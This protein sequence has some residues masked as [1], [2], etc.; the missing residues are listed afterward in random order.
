VLANRH[1]VCVECGAEIV[2]V[3]GQPGQLPKRCD[4]CWIANKQRHAEEARLR[5]MADPERAERYRERGRNKVAQWRANHPE[6][7]RASDRATQARRWQDPETRLRMK[8]LRAERKYGLGQGGYQMFLDRQGHACA[9]C[10]APFNAEYRLA[11]DHDHRC[12]DSKTSC[13][14]CVR[15]LLCTNC[16]RALAAFLDDPARMRAAADYVERFSPT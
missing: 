14:K 8:H 2:R 16:N 4:P 15:G 1:G 13:G 3:P 10:R 9:I 5:A 7:A 6:Q 11:V 12:C